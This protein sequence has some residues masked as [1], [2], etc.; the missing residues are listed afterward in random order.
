MNTIVNKVHRTLRQFKNRLFPG[1]LILMYHRIAEADSDPWG[2]CVTPKHFAEHLDVLKTYGK[3]IHL[4]QLV[5]Q[6]SERKSITGSI[7]VTFD[8]GYADNFYF[9]KPLLEQFNVPATVFVTTGG[10]GS[11]QEFW[12]DELDK[13]L[14]Q[15]GNLPEV[16]ELTINHESHQWVLSQNTTYSHEDFDKHR[17][18]RVETS[19]DP[20]DRHKLYRQLYQLLHTLPA[21]YRQNILNDLRQWAKVDASGRQ[22]HRALSATELIELGQSGLIEIGAHTVTHPFLAELSSIN[23]RTEIQQSKKYL[24]DVLMRPIS[25]FSYPNGSYTEETISIVKELGF[26]C[27]CSSLVGNVF[28][29]DNQFLLRRVVVENWDG[30][31][32]ANWLSGWIGI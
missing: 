14:L 30:D 20:S 17:Y 6:L 3:P 11:A 4:Q 18:W 2:L 23:Q 26:H 10:I 7:V 1:A 13:I 25:S 24:E 15:P 19:E 22:T 28:S 16:L 32:F 8:D 5:N 27:A 29:R 21:D 31:N 12:W 9:A